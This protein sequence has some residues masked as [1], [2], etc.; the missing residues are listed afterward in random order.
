MN[1]MEELKDLE[2]E[3]PEDDNPL[4]GDLP[5]GSICS[6]TLILPLIVIIGAFIFAVSAP[7]LVRR[8]FQTNDI[9]ELNGMIE[10]SITD[11]TPQ[12]HFLGLSLRFDGIPEKTKISQS[13]KL[14]LSLFQNTNDKLPAQSFE[15]VLKDA[16]ISVSTNSSEL[17]V[18]KSWFVNFSRAKASIEF[19]GGASALKVTAIWDYGSSITSSFITAL[20]LVMIITTMPMMVQIARKIKEDGYRSLYPQQKATIV[21]VFLAALLY[22]PMRMF[23]DALPSR[24]FY[25]FNSILDDILLACC[26]FHSLW[27]FV[28]FVTDRRFV[29]IARIVP[30]FT[31][32]FILSF[33]ILKDARVTYLETYQF[34]PIY[35]FIVKT[36]VTGIVILA[37]YICALLAYIL[38][39]KV[40][41]PESK[42]NRHKTY[43]TITLITCVGTAVYMMTNGSVASQKNA[44]FDILPVLGAYFYVSMMFYVHQ[45]TVED[46]PIPSKELGFGDYTVG[47]DVH[48]SDAGEEDSA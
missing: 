42:E 23:S 34:F 6:F 26:V 15:T 28:D 1:G 39:S 16:E 33:T 31:F 25:L 10:T 3:S 18:F 17:P 47:V 35:N 29:T 8:I 45:E 5:L 13:T 30:Y 37:M 36:D 24:G 32:L 43:S 20:R 46:D 9:R 2:M 7:P 11:L 38:I 41:I 4:V 12:A 21:L 40:F 44:L 48:T 27:I 22:N 19:P 14:L